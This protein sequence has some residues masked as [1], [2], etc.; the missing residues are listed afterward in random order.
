MISMSKLMK[1]LFFRL[2]LKKNQ[3]YPIIQYLYL[4][5]SASPILAKFNSLPEM[6]E[7]EYG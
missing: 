1:T 5:N 6:E 7:A 3:K 2:F 4:K